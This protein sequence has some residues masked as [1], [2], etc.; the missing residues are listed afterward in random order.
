[1][2][3]YRKDAARSAI[4]QLEAEIDSFMTSLNMGDAAKME[5]L[6]QSARM[7]G[8]Y[9]ANEPTGLLNDLIIN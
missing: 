9:V 3:N 7:M 8:I 2:T 6:E 5:C 4:E 1:M